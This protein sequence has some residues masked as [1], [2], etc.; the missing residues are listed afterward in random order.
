MRTFSIILSIITLFSACKTAE[1]NTEP[2]DL[3]RLN[4]VGYYPNS[5]KE[6]VVIGKSAGKFEVVDELN[7]TVLSGEISPEENWPLSGE[8]VAIGDFSKL[9][10]PGKY[11]IVVDGK[12]SS[13]A[14]EVNTAI[15]NAPLNAAVK[16]YYYQRASMPIDDPFG[17]TYARA[18]GH[19]DNEVSYHPDKTR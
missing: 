12:L 17:G 3:I 7:N 6:F 15:Y 1:T 2:S 13:H 19:P 11:A 9:Q 4:Q 8:T 14:F 16:S 10:A 18:A 5:T